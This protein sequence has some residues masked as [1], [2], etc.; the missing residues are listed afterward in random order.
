[1]FEGQGEM[2]RTIAI[3]KVQVSHSSIL[4]NWE[5]GKGLLRNS[6]LIILTAGNKN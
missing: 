2:I 4:M 3:L 5:K 6:I 1:M